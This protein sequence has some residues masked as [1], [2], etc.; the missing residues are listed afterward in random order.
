MGRCA[1]EPQA[2]RSSDP[3]SVSHRR[4]I[5]RF[6]GCSPLGRVAEHERAGMLGSP[7]LKAA[8][9]SA[10]QTVGIITGLLQ[11]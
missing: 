10:Q 4:Y 1:A 6:G 11:L 8:L 5:A 2:E 7:C 3:S 9:D